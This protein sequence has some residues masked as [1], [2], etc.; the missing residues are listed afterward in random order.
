MRCHKGVFRYQCTREYN[1]TN[2]L[3]IGSENGAELAQDHWI[4]ER[5]FELNTGLGYDDVKYDDP[6]NDNGTM[7]YQDELS[8]QTHYDKM[9]RLRYRLV[10]YNDVNYYD[11]VNDYFKNEILCDYNEKWS[12]LDRLYYEDYDPLDRFYVPVRRRISIYWIKWRAELRGSSAT[13]WNA[14]DHTPDTK[15]ILYFPGQKKLNKRQWQPL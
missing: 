12:R 6:H 3:N 14:I 5:N 9:A 11:K 1:G 8:R 4:Y 10:N 15:Y 13:S 7:K 2:Y